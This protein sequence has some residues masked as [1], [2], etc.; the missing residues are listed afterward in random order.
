MI[1]ITNLRE[2]WN[3]MEGLN[4]EGAP[5]VCTVSLDVNKGKLIAEYEAKGTERY[6]FPGEKVLGVY[7]CQP[8]LEEFLED[9]MIELDKEESVISYRAC[10]SVE[11]ELED[12]NY[13]R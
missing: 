9:I 11:Y 7:F 1:K 12:E 13:E 4:R 5:L 10:F 8:E 6:L 3:D 2:V